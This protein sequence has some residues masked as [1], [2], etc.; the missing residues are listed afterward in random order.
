M[1]SVQVSKPKGGLEEIIRTKGYQDF[2]HFVSLALEN[3]VLAEI[4]NKN[5]WKI[6]QKY[7]DKTIDNIETIQTKNTQALYLLPNSVVNTSPPPGD[8]ILVGKILWGQYYR[9]LP[10]KFAVRVLANMSSSSF[11]SVTEFIEAS[12]SSC[13]SIR[14]VLNR[15]DNRQRN[16]FGERLSAGFPDRTEKSIRRFTEHF[17]IS[18]RKGTFKLDGML[19]RLKFANVTM[20]DDREFIGL[21][22]FGKKFAELHNY[23]LDDGNPP[24]LSDEEVQ[25]LLDHIS[26][27]LPNEAD[28]IRTV[29]N[30][31]KSEN[32]TRNTL[33][34]SLRSYYEKYF[35]GGAWS[36]AVINTMRAG[37]L[38]RLFEMGLIQRKKNGK[39]L[40]YNLTTVGEKFIETFSIDSKEQRHQD[41]K[42]NESDHRDEY[43]CIRCGQI[44]DRSADCTV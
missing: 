34:S 23:V 13:L 39:Y 12:I 40:S 9:Y 29:L 16:E 33:N 28:H 30:L 15:I 17:L 37:L 32:N 18:I 43:S 41:F 24:A 1:R 3:Q 26:E 8:D 19:A 7:T 21:T 10:V 5:S 42:N 25:F 44:H 2:Q 11:P 31:I 38:S 27:N 22:E 14:K 4:E 36:D 35:N 6:E 20:T